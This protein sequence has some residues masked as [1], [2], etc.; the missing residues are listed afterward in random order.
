MSLAGCLK[1]VACANT[2]Q[3]LVQKS[4]PSHSKQGT[5]C[6]E[7]V[8][9]R[10]DAA[11]SEVHAPYLV[12]PCLAAHNTSVLRRLQLIIPHPY[13]ICACNMI[14]EYTLSTAAV[15]RGF[16]GYLATLF[17]FKSDAF[18]LPLGWFLRL[19]P[20]A[21][22]LVALLCGLLCYGTSESSYINNGRAL[23]Q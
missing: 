15:A 12:G 11:C 20:F 3:A 22:A 14:L 4:S 18:M 19:D 1:A 16:S 21:L 8:S 13:R 6:R 9:P 2:V 23:L 17:G 5:V 7:V 10:K